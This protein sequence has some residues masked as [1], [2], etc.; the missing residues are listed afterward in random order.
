MTSSTASTRVTAS[1]PAIQASRIVLEGL[2]VSK[3]AAKC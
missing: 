2:R 3:Q 1:K